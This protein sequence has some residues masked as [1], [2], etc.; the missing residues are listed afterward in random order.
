MPSDLAWSAL[1]VISREATHCRSTA[2]SL[3]SSLQP[4]WSWCEVGRDNKAIRSLQLRDLAIWQTKLKCVQGH[5]HH[6]VVAAETDDLDHAAL[7]KQRDRRVVERLGQA[8]ALMQRLGDI[9]D[10]RSLRIIEGGRAPVADRIDDRGVKTALQRQPLVRPPF[11]MCG[12][13]PRRDQDRDLGQ[14]RRKRRVEAQLL[15]EP[16]GMARHIGAVEPGHHRRRRRAALAGDRFIVDGL[17]IPTHSVRR[18]QLDAHDVS[19]CYIVVEFWR[20]LRLPRLQARATM[21]T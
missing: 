21:E 8:M 16:G 1:C 5:R 15:A 19:S 12:P 18:K 7:A 13:V 20:W 17:L 10:H 14:F 3:W 6:R 4:H 11:V 9:I 2:A